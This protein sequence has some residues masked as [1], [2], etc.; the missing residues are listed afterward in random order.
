MYCR[1]CGAVIEE[2]AAV[3]L[4]CGVQAGVGN[5]FCH[6][7]G[8]QPDPLA[9]VCVKCGVALNGKVQPKPVQPKVQPKA[10]PVCSQPTEVK[11]VK[12]FGDAFKVLFNK[13]AA[14]FSGRAKRA[15]FWWTM[16]ITVGIP[17]AIPFIGWLVFFLL[18]IPSAGV[19]VRRL[20]DIGKSGKF[21]FLYFAP[22][23]GPIIFII[24][25][26][27]PSQEGDNQYGPN[28]NIE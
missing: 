16:L 20:H 25:C 1:N 21:A 18:L 7:C 22:I 27:Q 9:V 19:M 3:C 5:K 24:W 28:P 8:A 17:S 14:L 10:Q 13:I 4:S 23:A 2:H 6:Q 11:V 15:E 12:T 26:C